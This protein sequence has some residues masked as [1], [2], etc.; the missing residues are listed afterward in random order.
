MALKQILCQFMRECPIDCALSRR[1][2]GK[3]YHILAPATAKFR[4]PCLEFV[5]V[6]ARQQDAADRRCRRLAIDVTSTQSTARYGGARCAPKYNIWITFYLRIHHNVK[7]VLVA[8]KLVEVGKFMRTKTGTWCTF[9]CIAN[10]WCLCV[11]QKC[12]CAPIL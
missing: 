6:T 11:G 1:S 10:L 2:D 9:E 12:S 4:V 8:V 5:P 7:S 3:L